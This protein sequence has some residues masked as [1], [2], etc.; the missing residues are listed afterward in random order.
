MTSR[1][2]LVVD[3]SAHGFGH[4]AMTAPVVNCL[5]R[6][7]PGVRLTVRSAAPLAKLREHFSGDFD[8]VSLASDIGMAMHDALTVDEVRSYSYYAELHATWDHRVADAARHL[9]A[10]K[11][12]AVLANVPYL[13]LAAAAQ[14]GIPA[15]ALCCLHW[16]DIFEH[17]LHGQP[18]AATIRRQIR[19]AYSSARAFVCPEPRMPMADLPNLH[20]VAPIGRRGVLRKPE[21]LAA[22]GAAPDTRVALLSLGGIGFELDVSRWPRLPGWRIVAGMGLRGSH[23]DVIPLDALSLPYIDVFASVDAVITKLGYGTVAEAGINAVPVLY[24]RRDGWPE[25]PYL[26][27]WLESHGRVAVLDDPALTEGSFVPALQALVARTA[28]PAVEAAGAE[29]AAAVVA[30]LL[31]ASSAVPGMRPAPVAG[32]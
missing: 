19:D 5:T 9:E 14:A 20:P 21:L 29:Q 23:P 16:G 26:A 24:V 18:G 28:P 10:L 31:G 3:I 15:A 6:R 30:G 13:T 4:I 2:H 27:R 7:W 1:P 12:D 22:L 8:H 25:E 11:P 32:A 17:Y